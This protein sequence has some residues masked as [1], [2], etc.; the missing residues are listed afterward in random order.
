MRVRLAVLGVAFAVLLVPAPAS[1]D[2]IHVVTPGESLTSIAATDGLSIDSLAAA[3]GLSSAA[4]LIT[5][6]CLS[7]PPQSGAALPQ[8]APAAPGAASST[9]SAG[10]SYV[11]QPGDTLTA[12]AARAG[13]TVSELAAANGIN[14]TAPLLSGSVLALSGGG[15]AATSASGV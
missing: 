3:N 6:T 13:M 8:S 15:Q 10:G 12:I 5:G 4:E 1:A 2:C 14:P 7:I 11:V 9:G